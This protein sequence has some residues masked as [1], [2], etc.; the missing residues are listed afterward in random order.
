ML[1]GH[2]PAVRGRDLIGADTES[3]P[4]RSLDR[5]EEAA[6][7]AVGGGLLCHRSVGATLPGIP[8][9]CRIEAAPAGQHPDPADAEFEGDL[10]DL[11]VVRLQVGRHQARI[12]LLGRHDVARAH[13]TGAH[14]LGPRN[15]LR[16][17]QRV[18]P[19]QQ[20][21]LGHGRREA[22][23]AAHG[24]RPVPAAI[25]AQLGGER[26]RDESFALRAHPQVVTHV[27]GLAGRRVEPGD[28]G[29]RRTCQIDGGSALGVQF[30]T[31]VLGVERLAGGMVAG[32]S[33][34]ASVSPRRTTPGDCH[35]GA[36]G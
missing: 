12:V 15:P 28:I 9:I 35:C 23:R 6:G 7:A 30:D 26:V 29:R 5:Q 10:G 22:L 19:G 27:S 34:R 8:A 17:E 13:V 4:Q 24:D 3:G 32:H 21:D 36:A 33:H 31:R 25:A 14:P 11:R 1:D 16:S 18:R 2:D 20:D